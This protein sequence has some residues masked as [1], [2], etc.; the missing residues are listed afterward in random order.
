[1]TYQI[2]LNTLKDCTVRDIDTNKI[3]VYIAHP[4]K[5]SKGIAIAEE[6]SRLP[7][8]GAAI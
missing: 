3:T 8:G 2:I 7:K 6:L 4:H 5:I 1:M